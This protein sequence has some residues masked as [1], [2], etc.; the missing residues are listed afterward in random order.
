M[1]VWVSNNGAR[2]LNEKAKITP[3][4]EDDCCKFHGGAIG[5]GQSWNI[6]TCKSGCKKGIGFRCGSYTYINCQ[7]GTSCGIRSIPPDCPDTIPPAPTL[8]KNSNG[9]EK[10]KRDRKMNAKMIFYSNSTIKF[11]FEN[12]LPKSEMNNNIMEVEGE[13]LNEFPVK[14]FLDNKPYRGYIPLEGN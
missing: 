2:I 14:V 1:T 3:F 4:E 9:P 11:V 12:S 7:D 13:S 5:V 6:A 10:L 8:N